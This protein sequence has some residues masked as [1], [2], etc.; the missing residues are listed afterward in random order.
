LINTGHKFVKTSGDYTFEGEVIAV[1]TKKS[2]AARYVVEDD[3]GLLLIMNE[4][5]VQGA[6]IDN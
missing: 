2:G 5:Q 3:R 6:S 4:K 1:I